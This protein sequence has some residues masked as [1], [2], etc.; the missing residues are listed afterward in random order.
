M[1]CNVERNTRRSKYRGLDKIRDT[2]LPNRIRDLL[3]HIYWKCGNYQGKEDVWVQ[4]MDL[5]HGEPYVLGLF[6]LQTSTSTT[7]ME[8]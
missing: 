4:L 8:E 7:K 1:L 6:N 5:L 2:M 3:E